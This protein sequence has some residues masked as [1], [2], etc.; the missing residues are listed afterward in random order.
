MAQRNVRAP[1]WLPPLY[2]APGPASLISTQKADA[3]VASILP[4][5]Q[6]STPGASLP[7]TTRD[8]T[9]PAPEPVAQRR[10]A[11]EKSDRR[12]AL[13]RG[14]RWLLAAAILGIVG[15][16]TAAAT[17][18]AFY[19]P[20]NAPASRLQSLTDGGQR[21]QPRHPP[22]VEQRRRDARAEQPVPPVN[23]AASTAPG[24]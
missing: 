10:V 7:Q 16:A 14:A 17:Q 8:Q 22:S 11:A 4:K 18:I 20:A 3:L 12:R 6:T 19:A 9:L 5:L 15:A 2:A 13:P 21:A 23:S 1:I 24:V